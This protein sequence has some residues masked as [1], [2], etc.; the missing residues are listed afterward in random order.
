[1]GSEVRLGG[2]QPGSEEQEQAMDNGSTEQVQVIYAVGA[3]AVSLL[4][5]LR[6][7]R[8]NRIKCGCIE[9]ERDVQGSSQGTERSEGESANEAA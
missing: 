6:L 3:V 1:M 5:A 8:C 2:A 4:A 9:V 7:S